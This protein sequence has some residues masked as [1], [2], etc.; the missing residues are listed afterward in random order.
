M[1]GKSPK[2]P[3]WSL[4][5]ALVVMGLL[6]IIFGAEISQNGFSNPNDPGPRLFPVGLSLCL[7]AGGLYFLGGKLKTS[8]SKPTGRG[9]TRER[10]GLKSWLRHEGN[11]NFLILLLA[12]VLYIPAI[13]VLGYGLSTL[14]FAAAMMIR[15]RIKWWLAMGVSVGAVVLIQLLFVSLFKVQLPAGMLGLP[16]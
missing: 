2:A 10:H 13:S 3:G 6:G 11:Q 5:V 1:N 4:G 15:L 9:Q 14:L 8:V 12:I 16:F 7:I